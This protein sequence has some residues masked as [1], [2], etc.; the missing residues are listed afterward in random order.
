MQQYLDQAKLHERKQSDAG[1]KYQC[2]IV[3]EKL[4]SHEP[5]PNLISVRDPRSS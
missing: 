4:D 1:S 3:P 5:H 2:R